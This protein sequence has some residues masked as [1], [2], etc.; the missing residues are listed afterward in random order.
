MIYQDHELVRKT[1]TMTKNLTTQERSAIR[2]LIP[3]PP[4]HTQT[5]TPQSQSRTHMTHSPILP[6]LTPHERIITTQR[7][8][9]VPEA[10]HRST[11]LTNTYQA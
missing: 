2:V 9:I 6:Y 8:H 1:L 5:P 10:Q 7:S 3:H 4:T 11:I